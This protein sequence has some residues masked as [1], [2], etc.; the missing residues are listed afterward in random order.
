MPYSGLPFL[1]MSY[2]ESPLSSVL[3]VDPSASTLVHRVWRSTYP[4]K[5]R[6]DYALKRCDHAYVI[7]VDQGRRSSQP[8]RRIAPRHATTRHAT[9]NYYYDEWQKASEKFATA[10]KNC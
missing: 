5:L 10:S 4:T 1:A 6:G 3:N 8:S 7:G 9:N 2:P